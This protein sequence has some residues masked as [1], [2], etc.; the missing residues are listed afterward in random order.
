MLSRVITCIYAI[1]LASLKSA[2]VIW[3]PALFPP[4]C[5]LC[6]GGNAM[7]TMESTFLARRSRHCPL[8]CTGLTN[9]SDPASDTVDLNLSV[10]VGRDFFRLLMQLTF[11]VSP[12]GPCPCIQFQ[13]Q[14]NSSCDAATLIRT[15]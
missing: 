3:F 11:K 12:L 13:E 8:V 5:T 4:V 7:R 14:V 2:W 6:P 10:T 1:S 9:L 15:L